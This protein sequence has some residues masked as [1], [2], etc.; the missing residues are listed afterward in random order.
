MKNLS[1]C[2]FSFV[3]FLI[4]IFT[5]IISPV[6][7]GS[8]NESHQYNQP[9]KASNKHGA[10][11][12][13]TPGNPIEHLQDQ[14]DALQA[15]VDSLTNV[16]QEVTVDCAAGATVTDA[17]ASAANS[18]VPLT[19]TISGICEESIQ[20]DRDDVIIRGNSTADGFSL[21][22]SAL[23]VVINI[24]SGS[25]V[26]LESLSVEGGRVGISV[27]SGNVKVSGVEVRNA[28][29]AG[30]SIGFSGFVELD[31]SLI[32]TNIQGINVNAGGTLR[33]S[34]TVIEDN[35]LYGIIASNAASIIIADNTDTQTIIR[36]NQYGLTVSLNASVI[37]SGALIENNAL[38]GIHAITGGSVEFFIFPSTVQNNGGSGVYVGETSSV[39]FLNS[40]STITG[41]SIFGIE[42]EPG[43][44]YRTPRSGPGNVSGNNAGDIQS[45]CD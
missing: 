25:R 18:D 32:T 7:A 16:P 4:F 26:I 27:L 2:S 15:Q 14:I 22:T 19:I 23:Q 5:A 35:T 45:T 28:S 24:T 1:R 41:N 6:L 43:S 30:I 39:V 11:S 8:I 20:I 38:H 36:N 29:S 42:C 21:P 33:T 31:N 12:H 10:S 9:V 44:A 34:N 40:S 13:Y 37:V 3:S 17:L